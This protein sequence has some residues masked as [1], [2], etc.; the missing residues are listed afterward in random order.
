MLRR[1]LRINEGSSVLK[2]MVSISS[3]GKEEGE[4]SSLFDI[5]SKQFEG[6]SIYMDFG[7]TTPLDFRAL[8][9]MLPYMT[10]MY[11]NPHSRCVNI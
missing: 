6:R 2:R 5:R 9:A 8:D 3:S 10:E 1:A 11:G 7:S 4:I